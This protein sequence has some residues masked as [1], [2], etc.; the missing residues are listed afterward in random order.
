MQKLI[1]SSKTIVNKELKNIKQMLIINGFPNKIV[2]VEIKHTI[3][4]VNQ[5]NKHCNTPANKQ[6]FIKHFY[7]N[8]MHYNNKLD[9]NIFKTLIKRNILPMDLTKKQV[10][11]SHIL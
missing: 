6:K 10:K 11:T 3:R 1:S 8:K 2:D 4:N 7:R 9:E 5:Q